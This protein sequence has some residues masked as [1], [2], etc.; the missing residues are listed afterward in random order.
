MGFLPLPA[1]LGLTP[2]AL[3]EFTAYRPI[4]SR[5]SRQCALARFLLPAGGL[6]E[7]LHTPWGARWRNLSFLPARSYLSH[8]FPELQLFAQ[9][10]M[11]ILK[12]TPPQWVRPW[13]GASA[14]SLTSQ[15]SLSQGPQLPR[16]PAAV[17]LP[18]PRAAVSRITESQRSL[19]VA[20]LPRSPP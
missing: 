3:L 9:D 7:T 4:T 5:N 11:Q 19:R 1:A 16:L 20:P 13:E 17:S 8:L 12:T 18:P 2:A 6:L 14:S 10:M 15:V